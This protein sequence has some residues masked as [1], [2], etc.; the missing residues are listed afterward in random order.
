MLGVSQ[1]IEE[2]DSSSKHRTMNKLRED[3]APVQTEAI[4]VLPDR[5]LS[6]LKD[7]EFYERH[8]VEED[9]ADHI[10]LTLESLRDRSKS[11][12]ESHRDRDL[13][14]ESTFTIV[15][16]SNLFQENSRWWSMIDNSH[17]N[18]S[19][20]AAPNPSRNI[21]TSAINGSTSTFNNTSNPN[22]N[23]NTNNGTPTSTTIAN[24]G[25]NNSANNNNT[26]NNHFYNARSPTR[27]RSSLL[28][29]ITFE[30]D[31]HIPDDIDAHTTDS[32]D[33]S[34]ANNSALLATSRRFAPNYYPG[35]G[36]NET[37]EEEIHDYHE[38]LK[39]G[40]DAVKAS[41]ATTA[42]PV[43]PRRRV[44][45]THKGPQK[46]PATS[47]N[48][49]KGP[50]DADEFDS[51]MNQYN[52]ALRGI[53]RGNAAAPT[54]PQRTSSHSS[55][56]SGMKKNAMTHHL[57]HTSHSSVVDSLISHDTAP[58]FFEDGSAAAAAAAAYLSS[59]ATASPQEGT[60]DTAASFHTTDTP[61]LT[62][63][64]DGNLSREETA[65]E[66]ETP[67]VL[68]E[69]RE[70]V[71]LSLTNFS[72]FEEEEDETPPTV[73]EEQSQDFYLNTKPS[74]QP[75]SI[76]LR[77]HSNSRRKY[78]NSPRCSGNRKSMQHSQSRFDNQPP[79]CPMRKDSNH[80]V[81]RTPD[82]AAIASH[83]IKKFVPRDPS[84]P[85]HQPQSQP[86]QKH[87]PPTKP[88]RTNSNSISK[89]PTSTTS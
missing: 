63:K 57:Y 68:P 64:V 38:Q 8:H 19:N 10:S 81:R 15:S 12:H 13:V 49:L 58:S 35:G 65:I 46:V 30:S 72:S 18:N 22:T 52:V 69:R 26:T 31:E 37:I 4:H 70:S 32:T 56:M 1:T 84:L 86:S 82:V 24:T 54:I 89:N 87:K 61:V 41:S 74:N 25:M 16:D 62:N 73:Y 47:T 27:R 42:A 43:I 60:V 17:S 20:G 51:K 45:A 71:P 11:I 23:T 3:N 29:D 75:P 34:W 48:T 76:P 39:Q 59:A 79:T 77:K 33:S 5:R 88:M 28:S 67:P 55:K 85:Q 80:L 40:R 2:G 21:S 83:R 14:S 6:R 53:A 9:D 44:S 78:S 7:G 36:N 66:S 50:T